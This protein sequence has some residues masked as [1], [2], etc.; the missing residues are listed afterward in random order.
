MNYIFRACDKDHSAVAV[1]Q[2]G[3]VYYNEIIITLII[4]DTSISCNVY[5]LRATPIS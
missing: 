4:G 3:V 1:T 2:V 5:S